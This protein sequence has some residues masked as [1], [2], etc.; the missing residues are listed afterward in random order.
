L[1]SSFVVLVLVADVYHRAVVIPRRAHLARL[2]ER[3]RQLEE[4]RLHQ[5][6]TFASSNAALEHENPFGSVISVLSNYDASN[7]AEGWGVDSDDLAQEQP[8]MLHGANGILSHSHRHDR[9][10]PNSPNVE[11]E[12]YSA[13]EDAVVQACVGVHG[14]EPPNAGGWA[15]AFDTAILELLMHAN[16]TWDDIFHNEE[17]SRV[18]KFLLLFELPFTICRKMTVPIP[19][20]GYYVRSLV[21][22][23]FAV[24]PWW[25]IFYLHRSNDIN[26]LSNGGWVY[27]V[28]VEAIICCCSLCILRFSPG[29]EGSMPLVFSGPIALYGFVMAATWIDTIADAL[30]SLLNYIGIILNIPA[31]VLG[32]TL[33]AWGNSMS[34]LSANMT[35]AR[36][37]L[38][39]MAMTACFAGPVFNILVGL[40]FG[41]SALAA[42]TGQAERIVTLSSSVMTGFSFI[43]LATVSILS[44]GLLFGKGRISKQYGYFSL[45][46]YGVYLIT[47]ITLQYMH[48]GN[49]N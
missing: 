4:E 47:S 40:G 6:S 23:S 7:D 30:V 41:F 13:L 8:V 45:M 31:P 20:K 38:A 43:T 21:A 15:R 22:L 9:S 25:F 24:S 12:G 17:I 3:D 37:G 5:E 49:D 2:N 16:Q 39:N 32:L 28:I 46:L 19:S 44:A 27:F 18:D 29:G 34:D 1:Y 10:S 14:S 35:M 36:K 11:A 48:G 26:V 42:R 33:L